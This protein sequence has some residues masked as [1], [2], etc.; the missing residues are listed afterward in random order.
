MVTVP[1]SAYSRPAMMRRRVDLPPPLGPSRAVRPPLGIE[2]ETSSR[3][4][5]SPKRLL[6][7]LTSMLMGRSVRSVGVTG[8]AGT[9]RCGARRRGRA[10]A[11]VL[12]AEEADDD[13]A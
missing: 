9:G 8:G 10:S 12:G 6:M 5:K 4:T 1:S 13:D 7:W 3:A 2:T 11:L